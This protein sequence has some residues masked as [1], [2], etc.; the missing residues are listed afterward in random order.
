MMPDVSWH[1][2]DADQRVGDMLTVEFKAL[3]GE[4]RVTVSGDVVTI[5]DVLKLVEDAMRGAGFNVP[6]ESLDITRGDDDER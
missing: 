3:S 6:F 5:E 4:R 2:P 1:T